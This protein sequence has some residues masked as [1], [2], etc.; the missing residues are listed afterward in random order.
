MARGAALGPS[1][2]TRAPKVKRDGQRHH[3]PDGAKPGGTS[4]N[5][6]RLAHRPCT[7]LWLQAGE[8]GEGDRRGPAEEVRQLAKEDPTA[9]ETLAMIGVIPPLVGMLDSGD[10]NVQV[11]TLYALLNLNVGNDMYAL[12]KLSAY[13]FLCSS[14]LFSLLWC[15]KNKATNVAARIVHKMLK[16]IETRSALTCVS[17][18]I[19]ANFL[20]LIGTSSTITFLID[21]LRDT[22][23]APLISNLLMAVG[24]MEVLEWV[25]S[26][27]NVVSIGKGR[28]EMAAYVLMVMVYK[29]RAAMVEAIDVH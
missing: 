1:A 18:M 3:H 22:F 6:L 29:D 11:A 19:I 26:S 5:C 17:E 2:A 24:D 25:L 14:S 12:F 20:G 16:L 13:F 7:M 8:D 15:H 21:A 4:A 23:V 10:V 28:R 9:Q 27:S